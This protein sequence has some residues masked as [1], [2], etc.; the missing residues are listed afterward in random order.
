MTSILGPYWMPWH[1]YKQDEEYIQ[2]LDPAWILIH[3]PTARDIWTAQRLAPN[4]KIVLRSWDIDDSNGV[5]KQEMYSNPK[6]AAH[7]HLAMWKE[8]WGQLIDEAHKNNWTLDESRWYIQLVNEPDPA[9]VQQDVEYSLEAMRLVKGTSIRLVVVVSSVGTFSKP[10]ENNVGWTLCEPL[11]GPINDGG[12]ILGIHEY[13]Q[14]EG[15]NYGQDGGNLAWRHHSIPLNVP[16]LV[17]EAGANGYIYGRHSKTDDAGWG[18]FMNG[19]QYAAQVK[20]YIE[21]CDTRV[22]GVLLYGLDYGSDQWKSFHTGPAMEQLLAIKDARPQVPSPFA[23]H[24]P[25]IDAPPAEPQTQYVNAPAGLRLRTLPNADA[26]PISIASYGE[27]VDVVALSN[28]GQWAKVSY[29]GQGGWMYRAYLSDAKPQ[30]QPTQPQQPSN[31]QDAFARCLAFVLV[32]EGGWADNPADPGGATMRGIT[33][34]TYTRWRLAHGQ[35]VPTKDDLRNISDAEV[36][37]IYRVGY[38]VASGADKLPW[39]LCL[40]VMDTAVNAGVGVAQQLLTQSNGN[41]LLYAGHLIKWYASIPGFENFGRAWMA[42]RGDL[43]LEA[44]K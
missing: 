13:W 30:P 24:L 19:A 36:N 40:V 44:S 11:E 4:A 43:L 38:W 29:G 33:I 31:E 25:A 28:D 18:K 17:C 10:S 35:P 3:Q 22:K 41:F 1:R 39:P 32:H 27:K 12:H 6:D 20:E 7:K 42:R 26:A 21:G 14:P 37:Q 16:I 8:K 5:R 15:P 23:V 9:F 2:R 34:G